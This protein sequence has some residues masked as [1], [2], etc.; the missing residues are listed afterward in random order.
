MSEISIVHFIPALQEL[1]DIYASIIDN[2][3][4]Y[5]SQQVA[6]TEYYNSFSDMKAVRRMILSLIVDMETEKS[7]L[8]MPGWLKR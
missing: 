1:N 4:V 2:G 6:I 5:Y 7:D 3:R 8:L